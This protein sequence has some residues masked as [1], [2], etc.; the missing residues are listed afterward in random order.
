MPVLEKMWGNIPVG[1]ETQGKRVFGALG[2]R[3]LHVVARYLPLPPA[4]RAS[5]HR[6][7]GVWSVPSPDVCAKPISGVTVADLRRDGMLTLTVLGR[8]A[9]VRLTTRGSSFARTAAAEIAEAPL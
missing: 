3:W 2:K 8:S 1:P 9:S 6:R 5:L 7:R 4:T